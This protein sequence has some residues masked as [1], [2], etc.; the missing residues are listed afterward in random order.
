MHYSYVSASHDFTH[1]ASQG[2]FL[3]GAC[4]DSEPLHLS[5]KSV[6]F[7]HASLYHWSLKNKLTLDLSRYSLKSLLRDTSCCNF[8]PHCYFSVIVPEICKMC[9]L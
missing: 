2:L 8:S 1:L 3:C 9:N 5:S 6:E 7:V 4:L